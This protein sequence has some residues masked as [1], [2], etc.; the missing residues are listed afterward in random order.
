MGLVEHRAASPD[1]IAF[2]VWT[3]SDTRDAST[4]RGGDYLVEAIEA[5]GHRVVER[6]LC[7]DDPARISA[8]VLAAAERT[9]VDLVLTTGGTGIA[10]TDVAYTTLR[11]LFDSEIPGFGELFRQLS[12]AEIGS[13]AI[14]SRAVGG[15]VGDRVVLAMPG[16]PKALRLAMESIVLP[17]AGHLVSQSRGG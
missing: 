9:D 12:H 6:G 11:G 14:L 1:R 15:L 8:A 7:P 13:A 4:D 3:F 2:A 16:S 5:A 17:E 10:P